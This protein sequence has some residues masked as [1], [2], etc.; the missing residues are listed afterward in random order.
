MENN[1]EEK[2]LNSTAFNRTKEFN[3]L[4]WTILVVCLLMLPGSIVL[5]IGG[6]PGIIADIVWFFLSIWGLKVKLRKFRSVKTS[7]SYKII[8]VVAWM[9]VAVVLIP[10][11]LSIYWVISKK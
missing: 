2:E 7:R 1:E 4:D 9:V 8:L 3:F 5:F 10:A 6:G 11:L